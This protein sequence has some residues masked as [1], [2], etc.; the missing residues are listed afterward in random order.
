MDPLSIIALTAAA[1]FAFDRFFR[2]DEKAGQSRSRSTD[3]AKP[4]VHVGSVTTD[5]TK[6]LVLPEYEL[7]RDLVNSRFPLIFLTGSAGTGKSTFIRWIT[8]EFDGRLLLAAPTGMA[9]INIGGKTLH[10]LCHFPPSWILD[11]DVKEQPRRIEMQKADVL[12]IDEISMVTANLLDAVDLYFRRNRDSAKPFGGLSVILIGDLF[13]LP[14]V[15]SKSVKAMYDRFY[16]TP[17]FFSAKCLRGCPSYAIELQRTFRQSEQSFIDILQS[18]RE[19]T[20]VQS[21]LARL[22]EVCDIQDRPGAGYVWLSPR[23]IEVDQRN[24]AE[25]EKLESPE[26][27][28]EGEIVADFKD[29]RLPSPFKL[30]VREGA[31]V[32]FTQNDSAQ[33]RWVNGSIGIITFL[34]NSQIRVRLLESGREVLVEK[35][36]WIDYRYLWDQTSQKIIRTEIGRYTQYPLLLAWAMTIHKSQGRTIDKVHVDLGAGAFEV[37]QTY[38]ALSR[39]RTVSGLSLSRELKAADIKVDPDAKEF[40]ANLRSSVSQLPPE[41]MA[42]QLRGRK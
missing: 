2:S 18:L 4:R 3:L 21:A 40:Y 13:Q 19:G 33:R 22:H 14:P 35:S 39:C 38:V 27:T 34:S 25:L 9:A 29:D 26:F 6:I 36:S 32:M 16:E 17:K 28:F 12:V 24:Q 8:K 5:T 41:E 42:K 15:V 30:V 23:N 7:V 11:E 20:Q 37:G 1:G 31:Q 10:S